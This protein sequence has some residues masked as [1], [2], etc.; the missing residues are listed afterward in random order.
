M[1]L[2]LIEDDPVF[3]KTLSD[4]LQDEGHTTREF[5]DPEEAL[6]DLRRAPGDQEAIL[7]DLRLPKMNGL[8]WLKKV[9]HEGHPHPVA[10]ISGDVSVEVTKE[11]VNLGLT[12]MLLKPFS[13]TELREVLMRLE[14]A[15]QSG[16]PNPIP[17][18]PDPASSQAEDW[19]YEMVL[20]QLTVDVWIRD[21][22]ELKTLVVD[23]GCWTL[24][25]EQNHYRPKTLKNYLH[26]KTLPKC[27]KRQLVLRTADYVMGECDTSPLS[28]ELASKTKW[29]EKQILD[30]HPMLNETENKRSQNQSGKKK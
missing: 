23:S 22:K 10:L 9:R 6:E 29:F 2:M 26:L 20:L 5:Q 12:A 21:G 13:S 15:V 28:L 4:R 30:I 14:H 19:K 16:D 8:Q 11:M 3:I 1:R 18:H 25:R 7:L 24:T 17:L 27:L